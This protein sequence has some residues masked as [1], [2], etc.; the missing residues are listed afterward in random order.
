MGNG[1]LV[2]GA[3]K[4]TIADWS[5]ACSHCLA[6]TGDAQIAIRLRSYWLLAIGAT[7]LVLCGACAATAPEPDKATPAVKL[8][9]PAELQA[10]PMRAP[11]QRLAYGEDPNQYG[12]LRVPSQGGP[13]PV[14]VLIHG[15]C[16]KEPYATLRDLAP[17]GDALKEE[18]VATWNVEYRR[19]HQPGSGWPGTYLDVG[20]A[21]D[22]L[23]SLAAQ[24]RLDLSRVVIVG[25]SAG[26]HLAMWAAA[27]PR[28]GKE[29]PLFVAD[30]LPVRGVVN[31]AGTMDMAD[32]IPRMEAGCGD[33]VVTTMLGGAPG[34]VPERYAQ[35]SAIALVPLGVPQALIW[36]E[37]EDFVPLPLAE[38]YTRAATQAGDSVRV[39][40]V[41]GVGHFELAS[42]FSA[43]WP[44]VGSAIRSL[45]DGQLPP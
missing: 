45:L 34:D 42:P 25:H 17:M 32:N 4:Q 39:V 7:L 37:R 43:A 12:E 9:T 3:V 26:G 24:Y 44:A 30:P 2:R 35:A 29:S 33:A 28:L 18:G 8:M 6:E 19:L 21:I 11:D 15:G 22:H 10:L 36:G 16:W 1:S 27:R 38:K 14:V 5:A 31:L 23:R 20:R 41:P 13:H 40:V